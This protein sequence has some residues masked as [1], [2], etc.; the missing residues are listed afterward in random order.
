MKQSRSEICGKGHRLLQGDGAAGD[1]RR[2][3]AINWDIIAI[4]WRARVKIYL[5]LSAPRR[6]PSFNTIQ[7]GC[8]ASTILIAFIP[9]TWSAGHRPNKIRSRR[10]SDDLIRESS[11]LFL[12]PPE[13][14]PFLRAA[15]TRS[16]MSSVTWIKFIRKSAHVR[17]RAHKTQHRFF[18]CGEPSAWTKSESDSRRRRLSQAH[19]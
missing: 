18:A 15:T 17:E 4:G 1:A 9:T 19:V 14:S 16:P 13:A 7:V 12:D 3:P 11:K 8:A 2:W 6:Y 5:L 10:L